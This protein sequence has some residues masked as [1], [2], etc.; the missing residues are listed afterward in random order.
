MLLTLNKK[1][2]ITFNNIIDKYDI[3]VNNNNQEIN[4]IGTQRFTIKNSLDFNENNNIFKCRFSF[5]TTL[6][7]MIEINRISALLYKQLELKQQYET[8]S[9]EHISKPVSVYLD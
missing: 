2:L 5:I 9:I 6:K 1:E 4:W 3:Y 7:G 8:I